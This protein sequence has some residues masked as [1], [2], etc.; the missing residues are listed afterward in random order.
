MTPRDSQIYSRLGTLLRFAGGHRYGG[1]AQDS[2]RS[3]RTLLQSAG[4]LPFAPLVTAANGPAFAS[5]FPSTDR[6]ELFFTIVGFGNR[7]SRGSASAWMQLDQAYTA[8]S[9]YRLF[10]CY[11]GT[12]LALPSSPPNG[13][14][15]RINVTFELDASLESAS[16]HFGASGFGALLLTK[17]GD[18][19]SLKALLGQMQLLTARSLGDYSCEGGAHCFDAPNKAWPFYPSCNTTHCAG[20]SQQMAPIT[21]TPAYIQAPPHGGGVM[22][23]VPASRPDG[24]WFKS[25]GVEWKGSPGRGVGVQFPW[26]A[27]YGCFT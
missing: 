12:E 14:G 4:W 26:E 7:S 2:A 22:V 16:G 11:R 9:G 18:D 25:N 10:D 15:G 13:Q 3:N 1:S 17:K 5:T 23:R 8:T 19:P 20:L 6:D 21:P 27:L 24:F